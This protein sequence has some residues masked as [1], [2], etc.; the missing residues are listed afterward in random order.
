VH[1]RPLGPLAL[2][3][4]ANH[5]LAFDVELAALAGLALLGWSLDAPLAVR[6]VAAA[7]FPVV[8]GVVWGTWLA[9]KARRPLTG[10]AHVGLKVLVLGVCVVALAVAGRPLLA[11]VLAVAVAVNLVLAVALRQVPGQQGP[12]AG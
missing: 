10:A 12:A 11:A 2:L 4:A 6:I 7:A 5:T 8:L 3:G 9:P 1:D